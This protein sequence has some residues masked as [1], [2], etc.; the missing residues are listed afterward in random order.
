MDFAGAVLNRAPGNL[1]VFPRPS[2]D[3]AQELVVRESVLEDLR[4]DKSVVDLP[5]RQPHPRVLR[6]DRT[7]A[8][9]DVGALRHSLAS[10]PRNASWST[11]RSTMITISEPTL[12]I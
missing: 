4:R 2:Q 6:D 11:R 5:E 9:H 1:T 10:R 3:I 12:P 7:D 8:G